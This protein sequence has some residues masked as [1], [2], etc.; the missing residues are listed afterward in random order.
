MSTDEGDHDDP[1]EIV[2][3]D[4]DDDPIEEDQLEE[5]REMVSNLGVFPVRE[6]E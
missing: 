4:D 3:T 1:I 5:Y 2:E 6:K